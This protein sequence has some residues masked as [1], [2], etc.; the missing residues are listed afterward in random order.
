MPPDDTNGR[1]SLDDALEGLNAGY[2]AAV[3]EQ[4]RSDPASVEPEWR[5]LFDAGLAGFEPVRPAAAA[6]PATAPTAPATAPS[7]PPAPPGPKAEEPPPGATPLRGPAARLA[8]NMAASLGVPTATSFRDVPVATLEARRRQLNER[9]APRKVSFTHLVGFAI[10]RAASEQPGMT[11]AF[12][13]VAGK[14]HAVDPGAVNLGLA[15]D[16]ERPDGSR[17]LVVPVIRAAQSLDFAALHARYEELVAGARA[18][19]LGPDD[20]AGATITLTNPG[21]LGTTASVPRLMAGQ[22]S[23]IATG[24]IRDVGDTKVMTITST[25]DH[26]VIQGAESGAFLRRV[27]ALL[28]GADGFYESVAESLGVAQLP[29]LSAAEPESAGL[30]AVSEHAAG[31]ASAPEPAPPSAPILTGPPGPAVTVSGAD[32]RR[33]ASAMALIDAY[34]LYGH[35]A[36]ELDPLG[37]PPPGDPALDPAFH[38]LDP[39]SLDRISADLLDVP[40][41]GDTLAEV[42]VGLRRIYSGTIAY[43]VEHIANHTQRVW[44]RRAIESGEHRSA[45]EPKEQKRLLTQLTAVEGLEHFLHKAYL[46]QKRFSIEGLDTMVPMLDL[47][48]ERA[49]AEGTRR[50]V[51]GMAHRGRLNVLVH[52]VGLPVESILAEFEAGKDVEKARSA[53]I[54]IDDVKYHLGATGKHGT[55][56]GRVEVTLMPNPSHLEA[57]DPVVEGRARAEQTDHSGPLV[58][59]DTSRT[60]PILIHGDAGFAAQGVVAE[61]FNLSRLAGYA[62]GGTVHLIANNQIGFTTSVGEARSTTWASD[63]AKGFDIPIIHVNADD[64]EACLDAVRLAMAYRAEFDGDFVID[65]VG[66]RRYGHNE[67]DEPAYTQPRMYYAIAR[68]RTVRAQY[69]ERLVAAGAVSAKRAEELVDES[70]SDLMT[71]QAAVRKAQAEPQLDRGADSLTVEETDEPRTEVE[72]DALLALNEQLHSMPKDFTVHPKLVRQIRRRREALAA[73]EAA[74]EWG[75]AETLAFGSLLR[76]R[77]AIRLTGQDTVRG[78]FSQRHQTLVDAANGTTWTPIQHLDESKASFEIHNSP[79]S[80]YACLGFEY[81]YAVTVPEVLVLWEAQFGDFVNGAEIVIDQFLIAGLAKW[82]QTSRLT[83]LLP[84]GYEGQGPEHS[85]ARLE[86]FLALGAE[87][88][89]RVAYPTTAAQYFHLL[90]RQGLHA[91]P[92]PLVVMTPKSLLR[93]A[94]AASRP[95]ELARGG[96]APVVDDPDRQTDAAA[97]AVSRVILC[98]GKIYYDLV[99]S[100]LRAAA[101]ETA[102]IRVE[103]LYPFPTDVLRDVLARYPHIA[104]VSWVQEEPRNMGARKFVLP[105]IRSLV[106]SE[107]PLGDVSRPE[108]SRPAEGYP[109]AHRAEQARIVRDAFA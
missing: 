24:A 104:R 73:D 54:E 105:K 6:A 3:Y 59:Q 15:V 34:R 103:Q 77:V 50:A 36:A 87:G 28:D 45:L 85:S 106:A 19:S 52:I 98:S 66:Y 53:D 94:E 32:L 1:S 76:D 107:I 7:A 37:S 65:L 41:G 63:L 82:S 11:R 57:V 90:R 78:T 10:A 47:V 2:V 46:G 30:E 39:D 9:V 91:E 67:A 22:G 61:T 8:A 79:L 4:Y 42:L 29:D 20:Y 38:G 75:H 84:H 40:V 35:L 26:R 92:R 17:F 23:I 31:P 58:R 5:R 109:G 74:V 102:I 13:D 69:A 71:R 14:P 72:M 48:L 43:E 51:I 80:E 99:M 60:I 33:M 81:G 49:A 56:R 70:R 16:V 97:A 89:I 108:R 88:N 93:L 27:A 68:Q 25:Y 100:E 62:N 18:G 86:R 64:P 44:L 83:L 12:V 96:W 101:P 95:S 55:G 21:T